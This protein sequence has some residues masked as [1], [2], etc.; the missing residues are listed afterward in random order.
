MKMKR[1]IIIILAIVAAAFAGAGLARADAGALTASFDVTDTHGF[2]PFTAG[3]DDTST[4]NVTGWEWSFGDGSANATGQLAEHTFDVPGT[5]TVTLTVTDGLRHSSA[6]AE[7]TVDPSLF[8]Y[9]ATNTLNQSERLEVQFYDTSAGGPTAW[10]WSFG[11]GSANTTEQ[12]P[13]HTFPAPGTYDVMLTVAGNNQ[14][15]TTCQPVEAAAGPAPTLKPSAS[16]A[17]PAGVIVLTLIATA[18]L[19]LAARRGGK[20]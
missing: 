6:S 20:K 13:V 11:D 1:S 9:F 17:L 8:A 10:Q 3:F 15:N 4:G 12:D 5:Y 18:V 14:T 16:P 19:T 7:V 2:A